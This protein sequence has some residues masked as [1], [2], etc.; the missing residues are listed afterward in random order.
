[1]QWPLDP[2]HGGLLRWG[3]GPARAILFAA[4]DVGPNLHLRNGYNSSARVTANVSG[5]ERRLNC[6]VRLPR[7]I[8][9]RRARKCRFRR[10]RRVQWASPDSGEVAAWCRNLKNRIEVGRT[11]YT[12][13]E[14]QT[15]SPRP[16]LPV[17]HKHGYA[18]ITHSIRHSLSHL[19]VLEPSNPCKD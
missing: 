6:D 14:T 12:E 7:P 19:H 5:Y 9:C 1:M 17:S 18:N 13:I 4:R 3:L 8:G 16:R 15:P 11:D 10:L 2:P